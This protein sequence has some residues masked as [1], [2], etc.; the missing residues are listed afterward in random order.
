MP[1]KRQK[2]STTIAAEGYAFL[3]ALIES[4][5]AKTLAEAIDISIEEVRRSE[6]RR[7][8]ECATAR[9]FDSL[10]AEEIKEE[11]DLGEAISASAEIDADE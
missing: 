4:G 11:N 1:Q 6:N 2:I 9:Y 8:L 7:E 10:T 5:K 3:R